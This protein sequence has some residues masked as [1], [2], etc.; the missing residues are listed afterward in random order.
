[1]GLTTS[2]AIGTQKGKTLDQRVGDV[3]EIRGAA[4][5]VNKDVLVLCHRPPI[6][7]TD[8]AKYVLDHCN[9][10]HGFYGASSIEQSPVE[11]AI[12]GVVSE[13]AVL[14]TKHA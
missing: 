7:M 9:G 3:Q 14:R 10:V 5:G 6:A 8:D 13:F 4:V 1:M 12:A 2:G 11:Q